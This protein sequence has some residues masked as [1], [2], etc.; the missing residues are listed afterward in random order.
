[1]HNFRVQKIEFK[2]LIDEI[3]IEFWFPGNFA[4]MENTRRKCNSKVDFSKF[5]S[6]KIILSGVVANGNNQV[7]S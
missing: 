4:S 7:C 3:A 5:T 6:N 1:M 2:H